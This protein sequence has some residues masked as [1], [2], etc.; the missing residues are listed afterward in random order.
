M[1]KLERKRIEGYLERLFRYAFSL[2]GDRERAHDLVQDCAVKALAAGRVPRDEPAY[3][4]WLFRILRNAFLDQIRRGA[5]AERQVEAAREASSLEIWRCDET[6]INGLTVKLGMTKLSPPQREIIALIDI[7][8]FSYAETAALLEVP[9]GTVMS[10]ISRARQALI[11][12]L[13]ESNVHALPARD[14]RTAS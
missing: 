5:T 1:G 2:A 14:R 10:R 3:R 13:G 9:V 8:G 4:A 7:V 11:L 12:V 6:L